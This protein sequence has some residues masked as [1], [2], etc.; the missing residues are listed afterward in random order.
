MQ[1]SWLRLWSRRCLV[2]LVS[3][4][5]VY[6]GRATAEAAGKPKATAKSTPKSTETMPAAVREMVDMIQAAVQSQQIDDLRDAVDWNE[7]KPDFG[8]TSVTD[9]VAHWKAQSKDGSGRDTLTRLGALL[10]GTP[11]TVPYGKDLENNRLFVW[12]S[13]AEKPLKGLTDAET[14]QFNALVPEAER[15][16][17]LTT[18]IYTGWR[19]VLGADGTWHAFRSGR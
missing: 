2:V 17:M 12:P 3:L 15:A 9:P 10:S 4:A 18:G 16:A 1:I 14:N 7:M 6:A 8:A 11:A 13:F 5:L 19:L